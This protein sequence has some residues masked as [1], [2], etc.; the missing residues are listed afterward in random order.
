MDKTL[1]HNKQLCKGLAQIANYSANELD[2]AIGKSVNWRS[3]LTEERIAERYLF[4]F[5]VGGKFAGP[6]LPNVQLQLG[7]VVD[8]KCQFA[9]KKIRKYVFCN[10][11]NTI[12]IT[13]NQIK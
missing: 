9:G 6:M 3:F 4:H 2:C 11:S 7:C 12:I 5:A 13:K 1:R 10:D 8:K